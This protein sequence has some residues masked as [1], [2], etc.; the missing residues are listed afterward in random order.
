MIETSG[1]GGRRGGGSDRGMN[2][3]GEGSKL[4]HRVV[5]LSQVMSELVPTG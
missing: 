3:C 2:G 1:D 4:S 5:S